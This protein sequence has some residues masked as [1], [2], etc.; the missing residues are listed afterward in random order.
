MN[1]SFCVLKYT[2]SITNLANGNSAI[3]STPIADV[4]YIRD[5]ATFSFFYGADL[6]PVLLAPQVQT[7]EVTATSG[8]IYNTTPTEL[9]AT[10]SFTLSFLNPCLDT[11]YSTINPVGQT[12]ALSAAYNE[13]DVTFTYT[14]YTVTPSLC[15]L[16]VSCTSVTN[17]SSTAI[18]CPEL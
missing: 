9:T 13:V 17:P 18:A 2:Y 3:T 11:N 14:P 4:G 6:T 7:V 15:L 16:Y 5:K 12:T 8:S 10:A 1:P